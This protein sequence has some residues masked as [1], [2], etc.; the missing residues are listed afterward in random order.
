MA[1]IKTIGHST[2]TLERF[3][4]LVLDAGCSVLVDLRSSPY[5]RYSPQFNQKNLKAALL[6]SGIQY[7][8]MGDCLGGKPLSPAMYDAEGH[9]LYSAIADSP[10]FKAGLERLERGAEEHRVV[11]MCSEE[12]PADCHR[13]L[14]VGRVLVSD[15]HRVVHLRG[16]GTSESYEDVELRRA[17]AQLNLLDPEVVPWKSTRSVLPRSQQKSSSDY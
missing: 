15:G 4:R 12:D 13:H 9:V 7:L 2:H 3:L 6:Q 5:S 14:L 17:P 1:L 11:V 16:D 8:Y 10:A